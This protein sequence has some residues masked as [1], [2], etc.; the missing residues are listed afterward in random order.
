[1]PLVETIDAVDARRVV[2]PACGHRPV[3]LVIVPFQWT[4]G[5]GLA[6]RL[7]SAGE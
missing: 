4:D 1:M 2:K 5:E 6:V 7:V 3:Y